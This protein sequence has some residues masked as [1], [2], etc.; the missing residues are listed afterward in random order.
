MS[1][2]RQVHWETVYATKDEKGVSWFEES[3]SVSLDLVRATGVKA[4]A[5]I[6]DVGGGAS[7]FVDALVDEGFVATVLDLSEKA[8]ATAQARLGPRG[9]SV[10]WVAE[11]VTTCELL[12]VR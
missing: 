10:R 2:D 11:D 4:G 7:R 3:P 8:L 12:P 5:S 6:I 9:A 1:V